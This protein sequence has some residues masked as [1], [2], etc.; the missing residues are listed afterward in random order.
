MRQYFWVPLCIVLTLGSGWALAHDSAVPGFSLRV[1]TPETV[2]RLPDWTQELADRA[3]N[4]FAQVSEFHNKIEAALQGKRGWQSHVRGIVPGGE[5]GEELL[6]SEQHVWI[7]EAVGLSIQ[8]VLIFYENAYDDNFFGPG[9]FSHSILSF[10]QISD[11]V[12]SVH[13]ENLGRELNVVRTDINPRSYLIK[14]LAVIDHSAGTRYAGFAICNRDCTDDELISLQE[15]L[16]DVAQIDIL[17]HAEEAAETEEAV[18][19]QSNQTLQVEIFGAETGTS[20]DWEYHLAANSSCDS[21]QFFGPTVVTTEGSAKI[22]V[23]VGAERFCLFVARDPQNLNGNVYCRSLRTDWNVQIAAEDIEERPSACRPPK[24]PVKLVVSVK[25][26]NDII[27]FDSKE[28]NADLAARLAKL[29]TTGR[30]LRRGGRDVKVT[31]GQIELLRDD[32]QRYTDDPDRSAF[33][34]PGYNVESHFDADSRVWEVVLHQTFVSLEGFKLQLWLSGDT[35]TYLSCRPELRLILIGSDEVNRIGLQADP[36]R[37][38]YVVPVA[39]ANTVFDTVEGAQAEIDLGEHSACRVGGERVVPISAEQL[40][41]G[42]VKLEL[43][44]AKRTMVVLI[45]G[46]R[47]RQE[48]L[49]VSPLVAGIIAADTMARLTGFIVAEG[50]KPYER[51]AVGAALGTDP[52]KRSSTYVANNRD[53][54]ETQFGA[55]AWSPEI[56]AQYDTLFNKLGGD[57]DPLQLNRAFVQMLKDTLR[58]DSDGSLPEADILLLLLGANVGQ[59]NES[60]CVLFAKDRKGRT[61][62]A[63]LSGKNRIFAISLGASNDVDLNGAIADNEQPGHNCAVAESWRGIGV[64]GYVMN[65]SLLSHAS[66]REIALDAAFNAAHRHFHQE[67]TQ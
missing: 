16:Q 40:R 34:A 24:T 53:E 20:P 28:D 45:S 7:A 17:S 57:S 35:Q 42:L 64:A 18:L 52:A 58:V 61:A 60:L 2:F 47:A 9:N 37:D 6:D 54:V 43:E 66:G 32:L 62:T 15:L 29:R 56:T 63:H 31:H 13:I 67:P 38:A 1:E 46:D 51:I 23:P 65:S 41:T 26:L 25:D 5:R 49:N 39:Y 4:P 8:P 36:E 3:H 22:A 48:V 21:R 11:S 50:D 27:I 10:D 55:G 44:E 12:H 30:G 33:K 19:A 59:L 14:P